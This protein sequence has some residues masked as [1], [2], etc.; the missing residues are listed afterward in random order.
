MTI[1]AK[2]VAETGTGLRGRKMAQRRQDILEQAGQLFNVNGFEATTM[3]GIAK[4]AG[5]SPP[6]VFNYFGSKDNVLSALLFEGTA[7]V[8][9]HDLAQ[10]RKTGQPFADLLGDMLCEITESTMRIA[11]KRVWR[12]A[13][14]TNI[15]R[16]NSS[17]QSEFK[18]SDDKLLR[19]VC[20]Y[21]DDYA[22]VMRAHIVPDPALLGQVFFDRWSGRYFEFIKDDPM[23]LETHL[24]AVRADTRAL[25]ELLFE[26][27]FARS[28]PLKERGA[29]T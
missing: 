4:A 8:R 15:R 3:A 11:G 10:P 5:V 19:L 13:E 28:S 22:L 18:S 1:A 17:F 29:D 14:S 20:A 23:P 25:V 21:L 6:T 24:A 12:Y 2:D 27:A 9:R 16:A 26:D 7:R